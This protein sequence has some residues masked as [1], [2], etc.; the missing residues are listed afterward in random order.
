MYI[1]ATTYAQRETITHAMSNIMESVARSQRLLDTLS[2]QYAEAAAAEEYTDEQEHIADML[3]TISSTLHGAVTEYRLVTGSAYKGETESARR[4]EQAQ[5][6]NEA[7]ETIYEM[8]A[9]MP[10]EQKE[11]MIERDRT[12]EDIPDGEAL[13]RLQELMDE[14]GS[15]ISG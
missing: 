1:D 15:A 11:S 9:G 5:E 12:L 3:T 13:P 10:A 14:I 2:L 7:H 6:V 8:I 4:V